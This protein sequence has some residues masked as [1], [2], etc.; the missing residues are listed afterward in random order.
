MNRIVAAVMILVAVACIVGGTI[1]TCR[2][3]AFDGW[4]PAEAP[5]Q[6]VTV[7]LP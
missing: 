2:V 6:T 7:T 1:G 3:L 4:T 5:A